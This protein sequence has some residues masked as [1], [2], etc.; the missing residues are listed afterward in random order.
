MNLNDKQSKKK[1]KQRI[2]YGSIAVVVALG[3]VFSATVVFF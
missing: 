3:M 2:I 1:T